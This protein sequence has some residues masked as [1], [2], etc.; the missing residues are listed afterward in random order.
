MVMD[1]ELRSI[2]IL[3]PFDPIVEAASEFGA[4]ARGIEELSAGQERFLI[5]CMTSR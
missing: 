5:G 3:D 1:F 4:R 2:I